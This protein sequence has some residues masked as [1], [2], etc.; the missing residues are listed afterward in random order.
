MTRRTHFG[1]C[2]RRKTSRAYRRAKPLHREPYSL[3]R[4][5]SQRT[6]AFLEGGGRVLWLLTAPTPACERVPFWREATHR[7]LPHPLWETIPRPDHLDARLFAFSTDFALRA[8]ELLGCPLHTIWQR[9]D[10]RTGYAHSYLAE[11]QVGA[12]RVAGQH[13]PLCRASRRH[14]AHPPLPSCRAVLAVGD[15]PLPREQVANEFV[16]AVRRVWVVGEP[17][18]VRLCPLLRQLLYQFAAQPF[19]FGGAGA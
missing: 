2:Q 15:A 6:S 3:P 18:A 19:G 11:A 8:T 9:I 10:T 17:V 12:G 13:A 1:G 5:L 14:A 4:S 16:R 7:F